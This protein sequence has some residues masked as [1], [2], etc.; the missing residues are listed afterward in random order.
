MIALAALLAQGTPTNDALTAHPEPD[1]ARTLLSGR[2]PKRLAAAATLLRWSA[3]ATGTPDFLVAASLAAS[4]DTC[5]VAALLLPPAQGVPPKLSECLTALEAMA[6]LPEDQRRAAFLPLA[7]RL[8]PSARL[9]LMRLAAG[10]FRLTLKPLTLPTGAPRD[11]LAVLT[12]LSPQ[13]LEATF[14]LRHGNGFVPIAKLPLTLPETPEIL[15]WARAHILD[16]FGPNLLLSPDL[17][18]HLSCEGTTPNPRRKSR[19]DLAAPRLLGWHRDASVDQATK[20]D[21]FTS[22]SPILV[23]QIPHGGQ[24]V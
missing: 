22:Q 9:I 4:G 2:R 6:T 16:K 19:L 3:A 21:Q 20:L 1:A 11:F 7:A 17:V 10:S 5:E 12:M 14:A 8:P 18:F 23:A 15:A 24:G 13:G